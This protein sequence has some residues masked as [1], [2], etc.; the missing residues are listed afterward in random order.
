MQELHKGR[1]AMVWALGIKPQATGRKVAM[2]VKAALAYAALPDVGLLPR[3]PVESFRMPRRHHGE[4]QSEIVVVRRE[5][6]PVLLDALSP[7]RSRGPSRNWRLL[8]EFMLQTGMRTGEVFALRWGDISGSRVTVHSTMTLT[9]GHRDRTKTG[10]RRTVPL[11]ARALEVLGALGSGDGAEY[12]WPGGGK[13]RRA[14]QAHFRRVA[15][16][17]FEDGATHARFRPYDLR[18]TAISRWVEAGVP[19][20]Q[21]ARW[22]GNCTA[23]IFAHYCGVTEEADM[24]VL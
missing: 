17:L 21:C 5:E 6:V 20:A 9:H 16:V 11:N 12:L 3:S 13:A 4:A 8:S 2:Y 7:Q 24:P 18:H 14:Y 22:A 23:T 19:V 10:R 1:E 15:I